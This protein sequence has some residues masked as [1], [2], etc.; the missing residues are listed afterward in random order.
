MCWGELTILLYM[1]FDCT[2]SCLDVRYEY[3]LNKLNEHVKTFTNLFSANFTR[4]RLQPFSVQLMHRWTYFSVGSIK[5]PIAITV[6]TS[7]LQIG[8]CKVIKKTWMR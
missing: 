1:F 5:C 7:V 4:D 8:L 6:V 3:H 2:S